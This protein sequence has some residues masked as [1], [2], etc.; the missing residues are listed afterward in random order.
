MSRPVANPDA[1]QP[2]AQG[3]APGTASDVLIADNAPKRTHVTADLLHAAF[4]L[5][6]GALVLVFALYLRGITTGVESDA[7]TAAKAVEWLLDLPASLLQQLVVLIVVGMVLIQ[8]IVNREWLQSACSVGSLLLGFAAVW[9]ASALI[10]QYGS[11][12]LISSVQSAG[13]ESGPWLLPD[14]YAAIAAFLTTAGPRRTRS[15]IKWGWNILIIG[16]VLL[17]ISSWNSVTGVIVSICIGRVVGLCARFAIGTQS[18]GIWGMQVVHALQSIGLHPRE[19][20]RRHLDEAA[21]H[22]LYA[23]LEDDM[24]ENSRIYELR[25]EDGTPYVVSVLDNQR[26]FAGYLNQIWQLIRLSGVAVRHDRSAISANHHHY[27]MMLGVHDLGLTTLRPYGVADSSES[28]VLVLHESPK[29]TPCDVQGMTDADMRH[30]MRYINTAHRRGFTHRNITQNALARL[31][32]GTLFLCGWQNGDYASGSTNVALDKVELLS[33]FATVFGVER[34]VAAARE[35]WGDATL[36]NLIP[37][38]QKA[39]V[40]AATRAL[41]G[42]DKTLLEQLRKTMSALA[43]EEVSESLE[44]VTLSRFNARSFFAITLLVIAVGVVLTQMKPNEMIKAAR[45]ANIWMML[46]VMGF[47]FLAWV[48][49]AVSLG[50]FMNADRRNS[51]GLLCSQMAAGFTAVSMPAGIGPAFVNLQFLRKSG[52]R[53]T[54]AT[55]IMSAVW[56]VQAAV[57]VVLLLVIGIVNGRSTLSGMIPTNML[58]FVVAGVALIVSVAMAIP[59]VRKKVT[60]KY[61]PIAKAYAR[62]LL[63]TLTQP[64]EVAICAAGGLLLN[65]ATGFGFWAALLAFGYH[66]NP[67]ETTFIFLLANTLGSAVPTPGG[68]GAVEAAL[69][70][71]FTAVG[72][73]S[74][75]AISATLVY[76]IAFYWLR[77]P[78]GALAMKW[79]DR[80]NLI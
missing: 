12:M 65:L 55:A 30:L 74:T 5:L 68:L 51:L 9:G 16:A 63:E 73:P 27:A 24:V 33:L 49:S 52:Y 4:A 57:T 59:P 48:G 78:I 20:R 15:S 37:F 11:P 25:D 31:D 39:A 6:V 29:A 77:I 72:V 54:V 61:L 19:L 8:L 38:V 22:V 47:S 1:T 3:A 2:T 21:D 36:I 70:V 67:I 58:I 18:T 53:S 60:D 66:T 7:H 26:H 79:L 71:A 76:R 14:F 46:L 80:H 62:S 64:K 40:P 69:S 44:Q 13:T 45:D 43:P 56:A 10:S 23:T 41:P 50:G 28:S 75:I 35:A 42:W 32:D 17:I 34:T